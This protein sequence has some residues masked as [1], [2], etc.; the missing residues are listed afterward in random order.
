MNNIATIDKIRQAMRALRN[1]IETL[2]QDD[3][4]YNIA[5]GLAFSP[6]KGMNADAL[7]EAVNNNRK[8]SPNL[9]YSFQ[10]GL[11]NAPLLG[12]TKATAIEALTK[13]EKEL[14]SLPQEAGAAMTLEFT[15][16]NPHEQQI[17]EDAQKSITALE[18]VES[19][20][21]KLVQAK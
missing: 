17:V 2:G 5:L 20:V 21:P 11:R 3:K 1:S 10:A 18:K 14:D 7:I 12:I 19:S 6:S 8:V 9:V 15:V 16:S 4:S 13:F